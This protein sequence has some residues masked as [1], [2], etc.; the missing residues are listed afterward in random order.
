DIT[1]LLQNSSI[2]NRAMFLTFSIRPNISKKN[3]NKSNFSYQIS[4]RHKKQELTPLTLMKT[5]QPIHLSHLR[6][7]QRAIVMTTHG[8]TGLPISS[9]FY[10]KIFNRTLMFSNNVDKSII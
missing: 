3:C 7:E 8:K 2:K 10:P 6:L 4:F 9:S 5:F 1:D